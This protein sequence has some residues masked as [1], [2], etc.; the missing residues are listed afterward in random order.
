L[1]QVELNFDWDP[2]KAKQNLRKHGVGFERAA[3]VFQD[4]SALSVFDEKHSDDEERWVTLGKS[5]EGEVLVVVHTFDEEKP[6]DIAIRIISARRALKREV[7]S[8]EAQ[9]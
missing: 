7:R 1:R 3:M 4:S 9:A 6:G 5:D 8:Y 2:Q